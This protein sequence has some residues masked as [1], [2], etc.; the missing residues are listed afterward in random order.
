MVADKSQRVYDWK[1]IPRPGLKNTLVVKNLL[2]CNQVRSVPLEEVVDFSVM[3]VK[4]DNSFTDAPAW[5]T[6]LI[7]HNVLRPA[8]TGRSH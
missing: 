4:V 7:T 6:K 1:N 2:A 3:G 5:K 8:E